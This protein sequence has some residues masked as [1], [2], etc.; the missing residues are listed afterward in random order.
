M[1]IHFIP[2][3]LSVTLAGACTNALAQAPAQVLALPDSPRLT[4]Y[5]ISSSTCSCSVGFQLFGEGSDVDNWIQVFIGPVAYPSTDT[6]HGWSLT[7]VTGPIANIARPITNAV[8]TFAM[9]QTGTVT[10]VGARRPRRLTQFV[11]SRGV[12]ARE[13]N[14]VFT[15]QTAVDREQWDLLRRT[16][17]GQPGDVFNLLPP[18][19]SRASQ[20]LAF[21]NTG[22]PTVIPPPGGGSGGGNVFSSGI[23]AAGQFAVWQDP[24]HILGAVTATFGAASGAPL[25]TADGQSLLAQNSSTTQSSIY[26]PQV[27]AGWFN[28]DNVRSVLAIPSG[29]TQVNAN[30]FGAYVIN[31]NAAGGTSQSAVGYWG[32]V[33]CTVANS[34]CWGENPT[35]TD[36]LTGSAAPA[37]I[38]L[39]GSEIDFGVHSTSTTVIGISLNG[40][41]TVQP[42]SIGFACAQLSAQAP[43]LT[44]WGTCFV[45][46][47]NTTQIG[48]YFGTFGPVAPNAISQS[49]QFG[50]VDGAS[51]VHHAA[52]NA[53]PTGTAV[54]FEMSDSVVPN[55]IFFQLAATGNSPEIFPQG[56]D[57]NINL[58]LAGKNAGTVVMPTLPT[59]AGGGGLYICVDSSGL[60]Y[61]KAACP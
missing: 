43:G 48:A 49:I 34:S 60:L 29:S 52:L 1:R 24:T 28:Y 26:N 36:S 31:N 27:P 17:A 14:Q 47:D 37:G 46:G 38:K 35:L 19:A 41:A 30:G 13:L 54:G 23:P 2:V 55:G 57:T 58:V 18:A 45:S 10:I 51:V 4:T 9:P 61:K 6:M 42:L 33:V 50:A 20:I 3:L 21:D 8:L 32:T 22:Q 44:R 53:V 39:I 5:S 56:T 11:E 16:I 15:D 40:T 12:T 7:S 25:I 59:S